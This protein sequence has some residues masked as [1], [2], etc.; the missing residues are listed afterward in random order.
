M[1]WEN[2]QECRLGIIETTVD[3]Q[4]RI[5][6]WKPTPAST[7]LAEAYKGPASAREESA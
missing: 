1:E 5:T 4:R 3:E 6:R 7:Y 2:G